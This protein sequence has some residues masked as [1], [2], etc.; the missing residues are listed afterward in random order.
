MKNILIV[1]GSSAIAVAC[2]RR[3]SEQG[4]NL[5][6]TGRHI[7]RLDAVAQDLRVRGA[8][9]VATHSLDMTDYAQHPAMLAAC[10]AALGQIDVVLVAHGT[11]SDQAQ[12]ERDVE[13]AM[14][15]MSTNAMSTI[16]LLTLLA[17]VFEEQRSGM[18][19][20][21]SSV[22][23]D[24]GRPS[25]YVYGAAKAAVTTFCEGLRAR[26]FKAGVGVLTIK[27][28]FVDTPMTAGLSL[29]GPLVAAPERVAVDIV[30]AIERRKDSLYTPW[31]WSG[32][33]LVIRSLP[34]FLFKRVSL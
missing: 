1:G 28:G 11:L 33:M 20:V 26:L 15:E 27:P 17:G 34:Q 6:L 14:R 31:F 16:A 5:F 18:I 29:P 24:R 2:A 32:I 4:A 7:A 10:R 30:R 21:I 25:N 8:G 19:A 23:G 3:W 9:Q 13:S 12:C 22:A